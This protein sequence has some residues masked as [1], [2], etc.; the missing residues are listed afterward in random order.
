[1]ARSTHDY[2]IVRRP[3]RKQQ[4]PKRV[5]MTWTT[6]LR[7]QVKMTIKM[8]MMTMMKMKRTMMMTVRRRIV[9]SLLVLPQ[10]VIRRSAREPAGLHT[11][12]IRAT[13]IG[14]VDHF[15]SSSSEG[16]IPF[17]IFRSRKGFVCVCVT[18]FP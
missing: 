4:Q 15:L 11:P 5:S 14:H 1:M 13:R 18:N 12:S 2:T 7:G 17:Q 8:M 16:E 9:T 10:R 3:R 6:L